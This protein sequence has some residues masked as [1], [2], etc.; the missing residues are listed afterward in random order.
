MTREELIARALAF[1]GAAEDYPF[2][3]DLLTAKVGGKV[4]AWIPLVPVLRLMR[5]AYEPWANVTAYD[6]NYVALPEV[7]DCEFLTP[8]ERPAKT[9]G[10]RCA[11]RVIK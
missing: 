5:R 2:G 4:F 1:P 8:D 3:D 7:F 10:P 9:P 11:I 6:A